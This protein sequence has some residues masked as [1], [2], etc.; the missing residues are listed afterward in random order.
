MPR[1]GQRQKTRKP[2]PI[3]PPGVQTPQDESL[4]HN[5]LTRYME[6]HFEWMRVTGYSATR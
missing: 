1:A 3:K 4:A 6:D 5:R 2:A